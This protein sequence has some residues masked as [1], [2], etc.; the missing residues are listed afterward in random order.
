MNKHKT[1]MILFLLGAMAFLVNGDNYAASPLLLDIARDLNISLSKASLSVTSYMILFGFFTI[2][3]GPLGDRFGKSRIIKIAAWGTGLFSILGAFSFNLTSLMAVRAMNGAFAAGILP[4]SMALAGEITEESNR[5]NS[6]GK[7]MGL[8]FLGG[9]AAAAIGGA[10]AYIGSW[11]MVYGVY[12]IAELLLALFM[13]VVLKKSE[14]TGTKLQFSRVYKEALG[15]K[16]LFSIIS[17]VFLLGFAVLGSFAFTGKLIQEKTGYTILL[18]G[19]MVSVY[20]MGT[21][22]GG[23]ISGTIR[24]KTGNKILLFAGVTGAASLIL[25]AYAKS[26]TGLFVALFGF[27]LAFIL[28][29]STF[30]H[31]AQELF[32]HMR[33]TVMSLVSFSMV[34]SGGL[35]TLFNSA[36]ILEYA[37]IKTIYGIS[38]GGIMLVGLLGFMALNRSKHFSPVKI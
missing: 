6:L 18:V 22:F 26:S 1:S 30:V 8:M 14:K 19:L 36:V 29:Q 25:L 21:I 17:I 5:Q 28:L 13:T 2:L 32:P 4:V 3:F 20:G 31:T 33:G 7:I 10:L 24:K 23:R 12:G 15:N 9:A 38:A 16:Q 35:G 11:R 37:G 27:G 34:I